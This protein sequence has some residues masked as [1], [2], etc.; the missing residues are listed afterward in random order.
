MLNSNFNNILEK[1]LPPLEKLK[2]NKNYNDF[3]FIE[4]PDFL[5]NTPPKD[6]VSAHIKQLYK[7]G[8]EQL[9]YLDKLKKIT[10]INNHNLFILILP[11]SKEYKNEIVTQKA[12]EDL[13]QILLDFAKD[14]SINV[15]NLFSLD[16]GDDCF[17]DCDH[18]N[19]KGAEIITKILDKKITDLTTEYNIQKRF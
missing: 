6:R 7:Y 9:T 10:D 13:H 3:G 16:L 1:G 14:N 17:G 5:Y 8:Q 18:L 4:N 19:L 2:P 12:H 15:I 11:V